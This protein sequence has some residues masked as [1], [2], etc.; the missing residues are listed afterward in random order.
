MRVQRGLTGRT[1]FRLR[2]LA[3]LPVAVATGALLVSVFAWSPAM[4]AGAGNRS[5]ASTALPATVGSDISWPQCAGAYPAGQ[6]FGIVGINGGLPDDANSCFSSEL[7]WALSSSG[8]TSQPKASIYVNTA[9]PGNVYHGQLIADWPASGSTPYGAC[10]TAPKPF[11]GRKIGQ[12]SP[13][14]AYEYGYQRVATYDRGLLA[15]ASATINTRTIG[16]YHWWLDVES[17]NT[18]QTGTTG[19]KMNVAD[20]QGFVAALKANGAPS[21]GIYSTPSQWHTIV[22]STAGTWHTPM[23]SSGG[24]TLATLPVWVPGAS[25]ESQALAKCSSQATQFTGGAVQLA[26]WTATYDEDHTC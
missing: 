7:Q 20:L 2:R 9:D 26:Q 15:G 14:C 10:N 17:G 12:N 22:G 1:G 4:A 13:A 25:D 18:W 19:I 23:T 16:G 11:R 24:G 6:A 3:R 21:V 8:G 5:G